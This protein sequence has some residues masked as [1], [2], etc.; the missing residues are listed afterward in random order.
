MKNAEPG[1]NMVARRWPQRSSLAWRGALLLSAASLAV[2]CGQDSGGA[3]PGAGSQSNNAPGNND[4]LFEDVPPCNEIDNPGS[5]DGWICYEDERGRICELADPDRPDARDGWIC[6]D[7]S[8]PGYTT[9]VRE[10]DVDGGSGRWR[11]RDGAD[12]TRICTSDDPG[13]DDEWDCEYVEEGVEC[14][15]DDEFDGGDGWECFDDATGTHCTHDDPEN[16]SDD[17]GG[18]GW[19]CRDDGDTRICDDDHSDDEPGNADD[20]PDGGPGWDCYNDVNGRTCF[21]DNPDGGPGDDPP[22]PETPDTPDGTDDWDCITRNGERECT[23]TDDP[24]GGDGDW[25][26][27]YDDA[28][29]RTVC[30]DEPD[31]PTDDPGWDCYETEDRRICEDDNPGDP[32][33][34]GDPQLTDCGEPAGN[35]QGRACVPSGEFWVVGANVSV[36]YNDCDNQRRSI[37]TRT[38]SDGFF[39]LTGVPEGRHT[40]TLQKGPYRTT[41]DVTVTAD[42]T[43]TIPLGDFC[44]DQSTSIAVVT[45]QYDKVENVLDFL[46]FEYTLFDGYPENNG[47]RELLGDL[48]QMNNFDVIFMNC[49][50]TMRGIMDN[51]SVL[52]AVRSNLEA[53]VSMGGRL[54]VSDWDW[55]F[56]EEPFPNAIDFTGEDKATFEVLQGGVGFRPA[57]V[58]DPELASL[59]GED[60]VTLNFDYPDWAIMEDVSPDA[61][62]FLRGDIATVR[63]ELKQ[64]VPL[65]M[66]VP[67]GDGEIIFTSYHIHRNETINDIFSFTVLGFE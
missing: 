21:R 3:D 6:D 16:A 17:P 31:T 39:V 43:T 51:R 14:T 40:V 19:I 24:D 46:G 64:D 54:Y 13:G 47:T 5:C 20:N 2:S 45:G 66:S 26:C 18:G 22:G 8:Q 12:G 36:T 62:V 15:R 52:D 67:Y 38:D 11:C 23:G 53:Y 60:R 58:V 44:F 50:T 49:G 4:D 7:E 33:D 48:S 57:R 41:Y 56:I 34:P 29:G 55:L 61:R 63:G 27:Y 9:C 25:D 59:L 30:T 37:T 35:I 32:N 1:T 10:D 65:L 42:Q 28:N